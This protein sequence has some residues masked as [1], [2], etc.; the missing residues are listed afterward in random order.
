MEST[1]LTRR[2][3]HSIR[4]HPEPSIRLAVSSTA[5]VSA[6]AAGWQPFVAK[7]WSGVSM[8]WVRMRSFPSA[9]DNQCLPVMSSSGKNFCRPWP[10]A[11]I[12]ILKNTPCAWYW[13][14][15]RYWHQQSGTIKNYYTIFR[16]IQGGRFF[17]ENRS[18]FN[19]FIYVNSMEKF[20]NYYNC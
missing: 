7:L 16:F 20:S 19:P 6:L 13:I 8:F 3:M 1:P 12:Q 5:P 2:R 9:G 10:R 18:N 14:E 17:N 4:R 11:K 15:T